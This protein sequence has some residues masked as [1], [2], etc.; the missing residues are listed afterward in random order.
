ML[1][2]TFKSDTYDTVKMYISCQ[3]RLNTKSF[4]ITLLSR[5]SQTHRQLYT[6]LNMYVMPITVVSQNIDVLQNAI[7]DS[8]SLLETTVTPSFAQ[9]R[10]IFGNI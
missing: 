10:Q 6:L 9:F 5:F 3:N 8:T 1:F 7:C 4:C 2:L